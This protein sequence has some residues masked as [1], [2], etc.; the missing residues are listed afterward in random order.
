MAAEA[1]RRLSR[2]RSART[3]GS[4]LYVEPDILFGCDGCSTP[5]SGMDTSAPQFTIITAAKHSAKLLPQQKNVAVQ[6]LLRLGGCCIFRS[7]TWCMLA[8]ACACCLLAWG[9]CMFKEI[10]N[11]QRSRA[12]QN[13]PK[14]NH[15]GWYLDGVAARRLVATRWLRIACRVAAL[16]MYVPSRD[17]TSI[18]QPASSS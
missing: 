3:I 1:V 12:R 15:D 11:A 2:Q 5:Q 7:C 10:M 14:M 17:R 4:Q 16:R 9:W 18:Q 8:L 13:A 6:R